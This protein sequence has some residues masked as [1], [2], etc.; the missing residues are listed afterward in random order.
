MGG[1]IGAMTINTKSW[2]ERSIQEPISETII[3]GSHDGFIE[4]ALVNIG[5][6]R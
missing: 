2:A 6:L 5:L 4:N 1:Y 3:K